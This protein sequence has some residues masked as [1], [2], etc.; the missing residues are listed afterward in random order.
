MNKVIIMGTLGNDPELKYTASGQAVC[1][2]SV[3][4]SENYK[5]KSGNKQ[6]KTEWHKIVVWGA[7]AENCNKHL[8]KGSKVLLE[9]SLQTRSWEDSNGAKRYTTEVVAKTVQFLGKSSGGGSK[10]DD[11]EADE[12]GG[13]SFTA[14][15][16]PF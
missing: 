11:G 3:A 2:F 9:G 1:N 14:D 13:S 12:Q 6:T 4:T 5:D 10:Q 8:H 15:D 16:I 7:T